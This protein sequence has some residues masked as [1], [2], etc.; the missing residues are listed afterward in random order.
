MSAQCRRSWSRYLRFRAEQL[1]TPPSEWSCQPLSDRLQPGKPV[2]VIERMAGRHLHD[3]C[4]RMKVVGV[5]ERNSQ[6]LRQGGTNGRL[7]RPRNP[8]DDDW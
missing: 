4:R 3:V 1:I 6:P 8:H 5:R 2:V 7:P